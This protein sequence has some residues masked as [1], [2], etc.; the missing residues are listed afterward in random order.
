[1]K[2]VLDQREPN[3]HNYEKFNDSKFNENITRVI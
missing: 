2:P 3:N 1:M